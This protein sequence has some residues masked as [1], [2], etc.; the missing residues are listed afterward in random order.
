[1]NTFSTPVR[2]TRQIGHAAPPLPVATGDGAAGSRRRGQ[3]AGLVPRLVQT[4]STSCEHF[5]L[6]L[7]P[8]E[9]IPEK[10]HCV[11]RRE[12]SAKSGRRHPTGHVG[13]HEVPRGRVGH[14]GA[15]KVEAILGDGAG[16]VKRV[17]ANLA[18]DGNALG[19]KREKAFAREAPRRGELTGD[20]R[21]G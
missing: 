6:H 5:H 7:I 4:P 18:C 17:D 21:D 20:Q 19:V 12:P 11:A 15:D 2:A 3:D 8:N 9:C 10:G 1:M 14:L 16:F 13:R